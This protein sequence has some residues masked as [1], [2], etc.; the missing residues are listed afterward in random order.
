M[1]VSGSAKRCADLLCTGADD[2]ATRLALKPRRHAHSPVA[3]AGRGHRPLAGRIRT[4][5]AM[6]TSHRNRLWCKELWDVAPFAPARDPART[7]AT[8]IRLPA[9]ANNRATILFLAIRVLTF[10][11]SMG[12]IQENGCLGNQDKKW[13]WWIFALDMEWETW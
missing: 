11:G 13:N 10:I 1:T 8:R 4:L 9:S 6:V 5:P 7:R 3:L 12:K 2:V